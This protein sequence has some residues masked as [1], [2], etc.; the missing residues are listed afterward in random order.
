MDFYQT[1][2][3]PCGYLPNRYSINIFADPNT[4]ISSH[5]YSWLIDHGFRR[6]G[7]HLYRPQCPDC[8]ACIPTRVCVN[9]FKLSRSQQRTL[10]RNQDLVIKIVNKNFI[11][12]HFDL[13]M[14]YLKDRHNESPMTLSTQ[15]DYEEFILGTWSDTQFMEFRLA[16]KL[17]CVAV[18][19]NLSQGLSA[20]YTYYDA[21][22][23]NRSL[24]T[25]AILKLLELA[26]TQ[27][28]DYVYL[29]YWIKECQKMSYKINFSPIEG[30]TNKQWQLLEA[31]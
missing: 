25:L 16:E 2:V 1:P 18:F 17:I 20:A 9:N 11:Q 19:D 7:S 14:Q 31:N 24:G 10:K 29:G 5:T 8:N 22:F 3:H 13:Y 15:H 21:A 6:N 12:E 30:F 26:K 4:E 27:K 23:R 28:L